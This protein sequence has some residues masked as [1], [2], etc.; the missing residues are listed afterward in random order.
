MTAEC[1]VL[2]EPRDELVVLDL[3]DVLLLQRALP[4]TVDVTLLA[5][6]LPVGLLLI[7]GTHITSFEKNLN[8]F[9]RIFLQRKYYSAQFWF[10]KVF[11]VATRF[12]VLLARKSRFCQ[13]NDFLWVFSPLPTRPLEWNVARISSTLSLSLSHTHT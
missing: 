8:E 7:V 13:E 9:V 2:E 3:V 10:W 1:R 5:A 6:L 4:L 12:V 11:L